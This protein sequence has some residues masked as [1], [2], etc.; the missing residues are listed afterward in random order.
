MAHWGVAMSLYHQLW[1]RPE[2][3]TL[4]QGMDEVKRAKSLHPKT[5]LIY[6]LDSNYEWFNATLGFSDD[7]DGPSVPIVIEILGDGKQ[8][9]SLPLNR[10]DYKEPKELKILIKDVDRLI[11]KVTADGMLDSG[12]VEFGD[13]RVNK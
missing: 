8:L 6:N 4:K 11:I 10:K 9:A 1:D 7:V 13:A 5:E 2:G 12:W 3:K